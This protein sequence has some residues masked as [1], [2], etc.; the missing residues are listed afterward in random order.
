VALTGSFAGPRLSGHDLLTGAIIWSREPG[1][2]W[3]SYDIEDGTLLALGDG[4]AIVDPTT[5]KTVFQRPA[6][7]HDGSDIARQGRAVAAGGHILVFDGK[8]GITGYR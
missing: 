1:I 2:K 4:V 3:S 6:A 5:G 8:G 7:H